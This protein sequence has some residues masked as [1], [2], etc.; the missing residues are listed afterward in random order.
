MCTLCPLRAGSARSA[1]PW[2]PL[3]ARIR[4]RE[5]ALGARACPPG[6]PCRPSP[7]PSERVCG[8][9]GVP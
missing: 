7:D 9:G 2:P 8:K 3:L 6:A 4:Q 1:P 5:R